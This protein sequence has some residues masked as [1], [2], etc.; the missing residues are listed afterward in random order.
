MFDVVRLWRKFS[1]SGGL[2]LMGGLIGIILAKQILLADGRPAMVDKLDRSNSPPAQVTSK[3]ASDTFDSQ[4]MKL[5]QIYRA[6]PQWSVDA[7][8]AHE[9]SQLDDLML[10]TTSDTPPQYRIEAHRSNYGDRLARNT[11][12]KLLQNK[13]LIVLHETTSAASGAVNTALT[14]H[15]RDEDQVSYHAVICQ[16]GTIVYLVDPRKR[17]YGAGNSVFRWREGFETVQTN[18]RL[19]SSVN[20]FAYHISLETPPDGYNEDAKHSGYSDAQYSSLAW[21]IAQ[22]GVDTQ[23]I[24]THLAIDRLGERQDPR[25][26]EMDWLKQHL[27][28]QSVSL[29]STG[30]TH[31]YR[32]G[33]RTPLRKF[34]WW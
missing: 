28:L 33:D 26:L 6:A 14:P 16:D 11:Q 7:L 17:A 13:P 21:L 27:A 22:S 30:A 34:A 10:S 12:G 1:R 20:N 18:K 4:W 25:S 3:V 24:T 29:A 23:R 32:S 19:K 15:A 9:D 2:L 8:I 5:H 31:Q